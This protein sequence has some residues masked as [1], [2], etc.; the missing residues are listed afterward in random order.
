[1]PRP[2]SSSPEAPQRSAKAAAARGEISFRTRGRF[3]VRD[4][5]ASYRCSKSIF[6]VF[7]QA[8]DKNVPLVRKSKVKVE[9]EKVEVVENSVADKISGIG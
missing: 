3:L 7:A 6:N 5:N 9:E 1:M 2:R 4:I 8:D